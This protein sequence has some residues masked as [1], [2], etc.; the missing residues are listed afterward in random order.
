M[1]KEWYIEFH[2]RWGRDSCVERSHSEIRYF[3]NMFF[4][5]PEHRLTNLMKS[6]TKE[7][8]NKVVHDTRTR[9]YCARALTI[10]LL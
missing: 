6:M 10:L 4:F 9:G 8:S 7:G 3:L 1:T 2:D 5:C